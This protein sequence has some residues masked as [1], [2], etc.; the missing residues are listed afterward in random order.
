MQISILHLYI[1]H[2]TFHYVQTKKNVN[3]GGGLTPR[4]P[5]LN[6]YRS[7]PAANEQTF[8]AMPYY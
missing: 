5:N 3:G 8:V 4:I 2:S 6:I 1:S 7:L